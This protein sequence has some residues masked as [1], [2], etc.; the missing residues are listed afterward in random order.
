M[1]QNTIN[2]PKTKGYLDPNCLL[3]FRKYCK[4]G[5]N[6]EVQN[7]IIENFAFPLILKPNK[8]SMGLGVL[9]IDNIDELTA[10]IEIAFNQENKLYDYVMLVQEYIDIKQEFRVFCVDRIAELVYLK[11]NSLAQFDGN[12]SPLHWVGSSPKMITNNELL[13]RIQTFINPIFAQ[14]PVFWSGLDVVIDQ[15]DK[16]FLIEINT[17]PSLSIFLEHNPDVVVYHL[18][19]IGLKKFLDLPTKQ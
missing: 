17:A 6:I 16:M 12:L 4:Y 14:I 13:T 15:Y 11:D 8:G 10:G 3:E 5:S 19:Q 9:K 2:I 1:L 7:D 18:Y